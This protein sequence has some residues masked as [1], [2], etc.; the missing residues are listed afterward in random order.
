MTVNATHDPNLKSW[1]TSANL[2][3]TDFPIQNLPHGVF[4][5]GSEAPRGGMA[6][7]DQILDIKAALAA[8]LLRGAA[9]QAAAEPDLRELMGTDTQAVSALRVEVQALLAMGAT[10]QEGVQPCL[11]PMARAQLHMPTKPGAFTDYMTSAPHI[12]APRPARPQGVLPPCFWTLPIAY[13]S[14]ASSVVVSGRPLERPHGQYR[15]SEGAEF[16]PTRALDY[17]LEFAC[18]ISQPNGLGTPIRLAD[19]RR[20]VFGYCLL[21]DWS[22][23]DIQ[24]WESVLGP[25]QGKAFRSTISPWVVTAEA[26]APFRQAMPARPADAPRAPPHLVDAANEAD[27]GLAIRFFAHLRTPQMRSE[28]APA[29]VLTDTWFS[30]GAWSFEQM[31]THHAIGGCNLE[32]GDLISSGTL[33]G[34]ALASAACLVEITGGRVPIG[35]PNGESRLWLQDGDELVMTARAEREGFVPIGFGVCAGEVVPAVAFVP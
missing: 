28:G 24:Y 23:R 22:A 12:A 1:V 4:S 14:R 26:L 8:G 10:E 7:G 34:E 18:F 31:I 3:D 35:L 11:V 9:A 16:G 27:G 20:H 6:I 21:N 30:A 25:F 32:T 15:G 33:S 19:A 5:Q 17:E 13:N 2:P 29:A